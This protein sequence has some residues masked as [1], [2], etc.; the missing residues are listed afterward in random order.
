MPIREFICRECQ[1]FFDSWEEDPPCPACGGTTRMN[2]RQAPGILSARTKRTDATVRQLAKQAGVTDL[3][4][5]GGRAAH[6]STQDSRVNQFFQPMGSEIKTE[7]QLQSM[8]NILPGGPDVVES[9][10]GEKP[11][12]S[13]EYVDK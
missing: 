8:Y 11:R 10:R 5:R 4:N 6:P 9:L 1:G 3:N 12:P 7:A 13:F 2:F